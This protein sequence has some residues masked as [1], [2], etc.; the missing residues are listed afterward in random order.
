M[1]RKPVET[2]NKT[3]KKLSV[4]SLFPKQ[5]TSRSSTFKD[6]NR[7]ITNSMMKEVLCNIKKERCDFLTESVKCTDFLS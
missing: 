5:D 2:L 7:K 1:Q 3:K 4:V 6:C